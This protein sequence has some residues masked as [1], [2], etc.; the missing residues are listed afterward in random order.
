MPVAEEHALMVQFEAE[1]LAFLNDV[2]QRW[3]EEGWAYYERAMYWFNLGEEERALADLAAVAAAPTLRAPEPWPCQYVVEAIRKR[4][5]P[6]SIPVSGAICGA[7][8]TLASPNYIMLKEHLKEAFVACNLDGGTARFEPWHQLG[9][10]LASAAPE[11][12]IPGLVGVVLMD[13]TGGYLE[14]NAAQDLPAEQLETLQRIRGATT[15]Y[16]LAV[17]QASKP[18]VDE[19]FV[20]STAGLGRGVACHCLLGCRRELKL[21]DDLVSII[22]D[23]AQVHYPDLALPA[24]MQKYEAMTKER[25]MQYRKEQAGTAALGDE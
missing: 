11:T 20:L 9:C 2:I 5:Y 3:P 1:D 17:Q 14:E 16:K 4:T 10:R 19:L 8:M 12:P 22:A 15:E 25:A 7:Q 13:M 18:D 23:L 24:C 6:G 21:S